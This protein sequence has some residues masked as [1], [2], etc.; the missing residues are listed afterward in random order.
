MPTLVSVTVTPVNPFILVSQ[1]QAFTATA[2][3]D[4][5]STVDVTTNVATTWTAADL[6]N[7]VGNFVATISNSGPSKG[8]ATA[9]TI[10]GGSLITATFDGYSGTSILRVG[11]A[12][13]TRILEQT[14]DPVRDGTSFNETSLTAAHNPI[15]RLSVPNISMFTGGVTFLNADGYSDGYIGYTTVS[16][17]PGD[18]SKLYIANEAQNFGDWVQLNSSG[19]ATKSF[20]INQRSLGI[21]TSVAIDANAVQLPSG[22]NPVLVQIAGEGYANTTDGT[23]LTGSF[24][25][26][27]TN[28]KVKAV[29]FNPSNPTPIIG[30]ALENFG[31]TFSNKVKMRI[32][33][34]GE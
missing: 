32:E 33:M 25:G 9:G 6:P 15:V 10:S 12:N 20:N 1:T 13:Y 27:D 24:L 7:F 5:S 21:V 28:G 19:N 23:I 29:T 34:C 4:D 22:G 26:P 30:Y 17:H 16:A 18:F 31:A 14:V 8:T 11:L 2:T 3:Y